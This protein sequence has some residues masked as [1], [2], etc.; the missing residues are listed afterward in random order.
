MKDNNQSANLRALADAGISS[1][2]IEGRYKDMAYV[3]NITAHYRQLL[4]GIMEDAPEYSRTSAGAAPSC[5]TRR[6]TRPS[7]GAPPITL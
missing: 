2:K 6:P 5:S 4:D 7:T 3:K 1:F